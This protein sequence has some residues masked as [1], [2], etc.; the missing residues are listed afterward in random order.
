MANNEAGILTKN[1]IIKSAK[2]L[3]Y[4]NGYE[5]TTLKA[6][7]DNAG[8]PRTALF[9]YFND[10]S[11][12]ANKI[13]N[14]VNNRYYGFVNEEFESYHYNGNLIL[15]SCVSIC[16]SYL[17]ILSDPKLTRLY[18]EELKYAS[19]IPGNH[20]YRSVV[21]TMYKASKRNIDKIEYTLNFIHNI[22]SYGAFLY[23]YMIG[24]L[25]ASK[26]EITQFLLDNLLLDIIPDKKDRKKIIND[27]FD[28]SKNLKV[29]FIDI[30]WME[31]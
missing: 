22:S 23:Q 17:S 9:Y 21:K 28:I 5:K 27:A 20:F 25:T 10:K 30:F 3:L 11:D 26:E 8:V 13:C 1:K 24:E 4:N 2:E 7:S 6:I 15:K 31:D 16:T 18:A 12:I 14:E 29:K 19:T